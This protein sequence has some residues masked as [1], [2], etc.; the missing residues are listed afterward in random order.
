MTV[1]LI[2]SRFCELLA[3][4]VGIPDDS[5]D[6]FLMGLLSLMDAILDQPIDS[7]LAEMPL[8][9]EI[10]DALLRQK[11]QYWQLLEITIAHEQAD[12]QKVSQ[13]VSAIG[14]NEEHVSTLYLSAVDWCTALRQSFY[15]PAAR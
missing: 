14:M 10:K 3:P 12:W 5:N 1:P 8:R 11:G 15:V 7:I 6:L 2:R 4:F 9:S 13:L